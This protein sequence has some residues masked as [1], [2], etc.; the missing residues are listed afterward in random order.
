MRFVVLASAASAA[1]AGV[2][3]VMIPGGYDHTAR[4]VEPVA[5]VE[6]YSEVCVVLTLGVFL[7]TSTEIDDC[8]SDPYPYS[9]GFDD[10]L[11]AQVSGLS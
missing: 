8:D 5:D 1:F 10:V 3:A 6:G 4:H 11:G 7:L 2:S 9:K